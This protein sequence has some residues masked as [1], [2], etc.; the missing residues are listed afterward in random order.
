MSEKKNISPPRWANRILEW[1]CKEEFLEEIQGDLHEIF[2]LHIVSKGVRKARFYFVWQVVRFFRWSNIKKSKRLNSNYITMTRNNFKIALRVLWKQRTNTALNVLGIAIGI[3]CFLQITLYV[4]QELSF[5]RFHTKKDR[6]Y[7]AWV[8]EDYGNGARFFNTVTPLSFE[9]VFEEDIPEVEMALQFDGTSRL[10]GRGNE[11]F[12]E[13]ISIVS[14]EFFGVFDFPIIKGDGQSPFKNRESIVITKSYAEKYFGSEDPIGQPL[15]IQLGEE[16]REFFVSAVAAD[17]PKHSGIQFDMVISNENNELLYSAG[18]LKSWFNVG[19]ETYVLMRE[20]TDVKEV[21]AKMS[22]IVKKHLQDR[23]KEGEYTIGFQLLTDIHLNPKFPVGIAPVG[24]PQYV[25]ILGAIG[26]LVMIIACVNYTTLSVG[27]SLK[28]AK[29]VGVRKVVGASNRHLIWQY[30]SESVLI[31]FCSMVIGLAFAYWSLP[32]F[33]EYAGTTLEMPLS[34]TG[35]GT[36]VGL[37]LVIGLLSGLYPAFILSGFKVISILRSGS[38]GSKGKHLARKGM[39]VFQ[40]LLTVFLI[41]STLIMRKQ[42][43]YLQNKDLGY[44]YDA[45]VSVPLYPEPSAN[46]LS[47]MIGTAMDKGKLLKAKLVQNPDIEGVAMGS[48]VFGSQGWGELGFRDKKG[49]FREFRLLTVDDQYLKTFKVHIKEGRGFDENLGL[50]K[51]KSI[52]VNQAAVDY[53]GWENP[54]GEKLPGENFGEHQVI[55]VTDDFNFASLHMV[56]EPLIITQNIIPIYEGISDHSY[57]D[58]PI[59][60]LVF[61]YTGNN[62][63]QVKGILENAWTS[64]FPEEDLNFSFVDSRLA[65]QYASEVRVNQIVTIATVLSIIIASLGLLGLTILVINTKVKEIGIRKVL[66]ASPRRI[67]VLLF[68]SFS[69]Q[70]VISILLSIPITYWLMDN[71]LSDF[72]YRVA[73]RVDMFV[74]SAV[75]SL[76]IALTVVSYHAIRASRANPVDALRTE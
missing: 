74:L 15:P 52:I 2:F 25:Y 36:Y 32:V 46:R 62:L 68:R 5:D 41:S 63:A 22:A 18:A 71:W 56:V 64:T 16:V 19:P 6:I 75:L 20:G 33:N 28:R 43:D 48:H 72:A 47:T 1:Y 60:K 7:R 12:Q 26:L 61:R 44:D 58:S 35:F 3:A 4:N 49:A 13:R 53:F 70:L 9:K 54:I 51:R 11:R 24:N 30:L 10:V 66:G 57:G 73:I 31:A 65:L 37:A 45:V 27:Q 8:L 42:M 59:P 14:P 50:D 67:F 23:V 38:N 40:F 34:L 76:M 39:V 55:G 17:V 69:L 21:E 29:E